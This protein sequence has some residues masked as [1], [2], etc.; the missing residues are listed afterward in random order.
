MK[1]Y[2]WEFVDRTQHLVPTLDDGADFVAVGGPG[3]GL[4]AMANLLDEAGCL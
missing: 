2:G 3:K 1:W 4:E